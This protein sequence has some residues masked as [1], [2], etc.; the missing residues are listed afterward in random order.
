MG[1]DRIMKKVKLSRYCGDGSK[2]KRKNWKEAI[3]AI[4]LMGYEVYTD[5]EHIVF[6]VDDDEV[7]GE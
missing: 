6:Q 1:D 5:K 3:S 4:A 2:V 7:I